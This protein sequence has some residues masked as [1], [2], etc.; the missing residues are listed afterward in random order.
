MAHPSRTGAGARR[1]AT[2]VA[3]LTAVAWLAAAVCVVLGLW[4]W[5][6]GNVVISQAPSTRPVV[7]V[8]RVVSA[9]APGDSAGAVLSQDEVGRRVQ[10]SGT[11]DPAVDLLVPDRALDG[12]DGSWVLSVVRLDDGTGVP[13]VRGWVPEGTA[14]PAAPTGRVDLLGVVQPP[15]VSDIAP[16]SAALPEGQTYVVSA[17]DL[18]NRVDYPVA[19]AYVTAA[20]PVAAA[21]ADTAALRAVPPADP[22]ESTRRLDWRNLAYAAQW[23]VFA[24]FALVL[25]RRALRDLRAD[26]RAALAGDVPDDPPDDLERHL[27]RDP[28][29]AAGTAPR[30]DRSPHPA[31][32]PGGRD[33]SSTR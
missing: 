22:G 13:L 31:D 30:Q 10:V 14:A 17:A 20:E 3:V 18:V 6:R 25:W 26:R 23:W 29:A 8:E 11:V 32:G 27:G 24:A 19:S 16:S 4:Q 9:A 5:N 33:V 1:A 12:R 7:E 15:E 2:Q 21:G 28:A